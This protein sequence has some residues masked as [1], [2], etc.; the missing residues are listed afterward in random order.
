MRIGP[1]SG[2]SV[3][4]LCDLLNQRQAQSVTGN[5]LFVLRPVERLKDFFVFTCRDAFAGITDGQRHQVVVCGKHDLNRW[6]AVFGR[7]V[8]KI[9]HDDTDPDRGKRRARHFVMESRIGEGNGVSKEAP[10][11]Q[12][13]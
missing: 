1:D 13:A 10:E 2:R 11:I 9:A 7:V 5:V 8:E 3:V 4:Q 12:R 6:C